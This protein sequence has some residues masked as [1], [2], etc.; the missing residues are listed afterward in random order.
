MEKLLLFLDMF[1]MKKLQSKS[2]SE[3]LQYSLRQQ[4]LVSVIALEMNSLKSFP[5]Q[6][7]ST[8]HK[9][10][11]HTGVSRVYIFEDSVDGTTTS[12]TFE[13]CN[14]GIEP[15]INTLQKFPY[16]DIPSWKKNLEKD[17]RIYS[18]DV[19][20]LPVDL[21]AALEP[22]GIRSIIAYPLYVEQRFFGFI[23]FDECIRKKR[24]SGSELEL[25]RTLS[26]IV[27]NAYERKQMEVTLRHERDK[28]NEANL[29]KT[30]FLASISHEI[31][32]PMNAVLG[33]S[34]ALVHEL[35]DEEQRKMVQ[36]II[37]SGNLLLSLLNDILDL[38]KIEAGRME[39]VPGPVHLKVLL[40]E[41]HLVF[42]LQAGQKGIALQLSVDDAL[43]E[44]LLV[45]E[46]RIK[47][48]VFNLLGNAIKF[49]SKG[50]V[51]M[52]VGY[53]S[54][55]GGGMSVPPGIL[56][57]EVSDT[58]I[59]IPREELERIF[60][61]FVQAPDVAGGGYGGTGLGLSICRRL[62]EQMHGT[63]VV[64]SRV[65]KGSVFTAT[66]PCSEP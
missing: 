61:P 55:A 29:A 30:R 50:E 46:V 9:I 13:W 26:G 35:P 19:T 53:T 31:R 5:E 28:A 17:G 54:P 57:L 48:V 3:A 52:T 21:Q 2:T 32:S 66:I 47:Q 20:R 36:S 23:G 43:P 45:D 24:W 65:G 16:A 42:G 25:L 44:V 18:E 49:T 22:Q 60:E 62:V 12:N 33:F 6:I 10:G 7:K 4:E 38:S 64:R 56:L 14:E 37:T 8:L 51:R 39:I 27:A 40:E 59:G 63:L 1:P 41:I 34:E 15:Q 58:G 11:T